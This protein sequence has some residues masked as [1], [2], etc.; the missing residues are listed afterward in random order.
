MPGR[1]S[2]SL[3]ER[4]NGYNYDAVKIFMAA[5]SKQPVVAHY[6]EHIPPDVTAGIFWLKNRDPEN[7]RA[8]HNMEASLG[9]Y[10]IRDRP[11]TVEEWTKERADII[12]VTPDESLPQTLPSKDPKTPAPVAIGNCRRGSPAI[13]L[14]HR[15][16]Q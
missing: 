8:V 6:V 16:R 2:R 7:W 14:W 12:D 4:A 10:I 11:M 13:L 15:R 3:Y 9:K 1:T 5:G